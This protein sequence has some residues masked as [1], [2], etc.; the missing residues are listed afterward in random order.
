MV[1]RLIGC[2]PS[3]GLRDFMLTV[4]AW[5]GLGAAIAWSEPPPSDPDAPPAELTV[6][7]AVV[8]ALQHN[9]ELATLRQQHGV[10]AAGVVIA[11][12]YPFNPVWE[13]KI[14]GDN[15]PLSAGITNRVANEH[16]LLIDVEVRGQGKYRRAGAAAALSRADWEIAHQE[17]ALAVRV[18]RAYNAV[19]YR[20]EKIKL[21]DQTIRINED[22]A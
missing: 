20:Q 10:A 6:N 9:P 15:G 14:W 4:L 19:L 22:A 2:R 11:D 8:W 13:G 21:I 1:G 7:G 16:K 3:P 17:V 12:T 5:C 18:L